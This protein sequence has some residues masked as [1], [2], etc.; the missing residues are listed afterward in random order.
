MSA[1]TIDRTVTVLDLIRAARAA[2]WTYERY[3]PAD[4]PDHNWSSP[5][6]IWPRMQVNLFGD[7]LTVWR[8]ERNYAYAPMV[9]VGVTGMADIIAAL[10]CAHLLGPEYLNAHTH[11]AGG[12]CHGCD[13]DDERAE[14]RAEQ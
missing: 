9:E 8:R 12:R 4:E 2:G 7:R 5:K 6:D 13:L 3:G 10:F 11:A 1:P 14:R